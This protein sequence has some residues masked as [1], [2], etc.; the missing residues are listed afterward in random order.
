[1]TQDNTKVG[2]KDEKCPTRPSES[3][4]KASKEALRAKL[5]PE[6]STSASKRELNDSEQCKGQ[7]CKKDGT[8]DKEVDIPISRK[9][10]QDEI[11]ALNEQY[12]TLMQRKQAL[13]KQFNTVDEE[14]LKKMG[15]YQTLKKLLDKLPI[16]NCNPEGAT[17]EP[18]E[19]IKG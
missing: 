2:C 6:S 13:V 19:F 16:V 9:A 12:K 3:T 18:K 5:S 14:L 7:C 1:M 10:I 8:C 4:S 17:K 15:A 11:V